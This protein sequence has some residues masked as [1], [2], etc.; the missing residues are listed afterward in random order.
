MNA[1]PKLSEIAGM[2]RYRAERAMLHQ[3]ENLALV[4]SDFAGELDVI[5]ADGGEGHTNGETGG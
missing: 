2:L 5:V 4:L 3:Q 1:V